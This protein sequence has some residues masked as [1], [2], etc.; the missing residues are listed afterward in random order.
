[1]M[2]FVVGM[3]ITIEVFYELILWFWVFVARHA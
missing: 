1:M 3:P 2:K